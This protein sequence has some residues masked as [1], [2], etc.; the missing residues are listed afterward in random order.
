MNQDQSPSP[1]KK[2]YQKQVTIRN[3]MA[4]AME[5]G[6]I[7][8]IPLIAFGMLGKWLEAKY[9]NKLWLIGCILIA[10]FITS[11][12]FYKRILEI[13]EEYTKL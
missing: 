5:F 7:I 6:F 9:H 11:V 4:I 2:D 3:T 1:E 8:V 10:L 12:W 13:Y